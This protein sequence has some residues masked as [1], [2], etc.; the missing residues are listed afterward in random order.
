MAT[1]EQISSIL[2]AVSSM[3]DEQADRFAQILKVGDPIQ[4]I[5]ARATGT[6]EL[7]KIKGTQAAARATQAHTI[8]LET[9]A[10]ETQRKADEAARAF[11]LAGEEQKV[12]Q[13]RANVAEAQKLAEAGQVPET[14][15]IKAIKELREHD[16]ATAN[17]A[18]I[19]LEGSQAT[20][21]AAQPEAMATAASQ[22]KR[23]E[24][25][26]AKATRIASK[27]RAKKYG[28]GGAALLGVLGLMTAGKK[29]PA[30][31][32]ATQMQL[33]QIMAQQ[34]QGAGGGGG[35]ELMN[36]SRLLKM[37]SMMHNMTNI[38]GQA[39]PQMLV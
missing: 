32:P 3:T 30:Q 4:Q 8:S 33:M 21:R 29:D 19:R 17:N 2:A 12:T 15:V 39:S 38:T 25:R 16:P 35:R 1:Q 18:L 11:S 20:I 13:L 14:R 26:E 22:A 6:Q 10:A 27:G 34:Q 7:Q 31:D 37:I 28:I 23:V 36:A 24:K 9:A 5:Q